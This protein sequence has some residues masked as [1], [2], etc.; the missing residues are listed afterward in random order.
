MVDLAPVATVC[1]VGVD[2]GVVVCDRGTG[3]AV[4]GSLLTGVRYC[5]RKSDLD[6]LIHFHNPIGNAT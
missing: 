5:G 6:A 1:G 3:R 4:R 2:G